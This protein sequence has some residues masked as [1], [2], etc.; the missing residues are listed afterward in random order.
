MN[1]IRRYILYRHFDRAGALL[2][3]GKSCRLRERISTHAAQSTWFDQIANITLVHFKTAEGL[4]TAERQAI[5]TENPRHNILFTDHPH[6][7]FGRQRHYGP[8]GPSPV[9]V[10]A[11]KRRQRKAEALAAGLPAPGRGRPRGSRNNNLAAY[12][13]VFDTDY[14]P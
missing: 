13:S 6:G 9:T 3:V 12:K 5:K 4:A 8:F 11:R 10:A 14:K 1:R 7:N 2:Y